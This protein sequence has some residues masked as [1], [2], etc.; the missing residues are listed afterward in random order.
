[1]RLGKVCVSGSIYRDF[2]RTELQEAGCELILGESDEEFPQHRYTE[3]SFAELIGDADVLLVAT[4][5]R[6][7][8]TVMAAC[9]RLRA[10]VKASIGVEK[11]DVDAASELGILV[12]NSP[13]PENFIGLAEATVGLIVHL[14]KRVKLNEAAVRR[15]LWKREENAGGLMLGKTIG[16]IGMGRV[17]RQVAQRFRGWGLRL[18]AHDPYVEAR[19]VAALGVELTDF[20]TLLREADVVTVHT[21][22][23][24]ETEHM[25]GYEELQVMKRTAFV[26]NTARGGVIRQAD[27]ARALEEGLIAGAALDVFEDEPL[28]MDDALRSVDPARLILTPHIVGNNHAS[29]ETGH[30]MAVGSIVQLLQGRVPEHV[31]NPDAIPLWRERSSRL[32]AP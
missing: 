24:P 31:L 6:V 12:C 22:L 25:L 21:V 9:P 17:G 1:M 13:A 10:I 26:V 11:V 30:R 18:L 8:R 16:F 27:L 14:C 2:V 20:G 32:A 19:E 3:A 7:S 23:T 4:R 29:R 28:P 15:G 5:D